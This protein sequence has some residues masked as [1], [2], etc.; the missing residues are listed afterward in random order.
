[1]HSKAFKTVYILGY[2]LEL[3]LS[4]IEWKGGY[5]GTAYM[6]LGFALMNLCFYVLG[7]I[8]SLE[9]TYSL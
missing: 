7:E 1:M 8:K 5:T 6:D 9:N 2:T 4:L 3:Y